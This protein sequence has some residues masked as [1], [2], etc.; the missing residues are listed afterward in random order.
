MRTEAEFWNDLRAACQERGLVPAVR[1]VSR[2]KWEGS[3]SLA[4]GPQEGRPPD[5]FSEVVG[6]SQMAVIRSLLRLIEEA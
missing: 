3:L 2:T 1:K 5:E 6:T 4:E